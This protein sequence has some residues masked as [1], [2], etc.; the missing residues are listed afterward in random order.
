MSF[1]LD[2]WV[3]GD[4]ITAARLQK[5]KEALQMI[6]NFL[7]AGGNGDVFQTLGG[8]AFKSTGE[9]SAPDRHAVVRIEGYSRTFTGDSAA[10]DLPSGMYWAFLQQRTSTS[11]PIPHNSSLTVLSELY[12]DVDAASPVI[13][14][15]FDEYGAAS[16]HN[17]VATVRVPCLNLFEATAAAAN[18]TNYPVSNGMTFDLYGFHGFTLA[19]PA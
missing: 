2:D 6:A 10:Y 3:S 19:C 4:P 5:E 1:V 17:L 8:T 9:S 12:E 16:E 15:N 11:W 13:L 18:G 7:G 14:V